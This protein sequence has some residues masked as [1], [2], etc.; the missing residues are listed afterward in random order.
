MQLE[1]RDGTGERL[2]A[3]ER[4]IYAAS[5]WIML[6]CLILAGRAEVELA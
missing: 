1:T 5:M 6:W 3:K 2:L 4:G